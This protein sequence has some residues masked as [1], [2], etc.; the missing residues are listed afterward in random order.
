MKQH[1]NDEF[2]TYQKIHGAVQPMYKVDGK[3]RT[4]HMTAQHL[5]DHHGM[6]LGEAYKYVHEIQ[7]GN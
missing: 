5:M 7:T 3:F 2:W 1:N 6:T 4:E